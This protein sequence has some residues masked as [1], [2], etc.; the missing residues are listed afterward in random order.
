MVMINED[1]LHKDPDN[2]DAD[3]TSGSESDSVFTYF[4]TPVI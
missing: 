3:S 4:Y 1:H 2:G